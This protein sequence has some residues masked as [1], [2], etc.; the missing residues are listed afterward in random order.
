[1]FIKVQLKE[2][3]WL[4]THSSDLKFTTAICN[5]LL[6][7]LLLLPP[8]FTFFF[9]VEG[10]NALLRCS[11]VPPP[12]SPESPHDRRWCYQTVWSFMAV[13]LPDRCFSENF[14]LKDTG[15][16]SHRVFGSWSKRCCFCSLVC[17]GWIRYL[18]LIPAHAFW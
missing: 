4:R 6:W 13:W 12:T 17:L 15:V 14:H 1:M 10:A 8:M 5:S 11:S 16:C 3:L 18:K 9:F 2:T 7:F